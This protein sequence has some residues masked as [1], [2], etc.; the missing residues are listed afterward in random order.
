MDQNKI[1]LC[2]H[3]KKIPMKFFYLIQLLNIGSALLLVYYFIAGLTDGS[4][5][6]QNIV[7]WLVLLL[8]FGLLLAG[9]IILYNHQKFVTAWIIAGVLCVPALIAL[10]YLG[11]YLMGLLKWN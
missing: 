3:S 4:I 9:S 10:G 6:H 7:M 1:L 2:C 11:L 5:N 8:L